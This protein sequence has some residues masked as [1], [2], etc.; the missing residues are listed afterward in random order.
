MNRALK[1][2]LIFG[3]ILGSPLPET[4]AQVPKEKTLPFTAEENADG[5]RFVWFVYGTVGYSYDYVSTKE[6]PSSPAFKL[7]ANVPQDQDIAWWPDFIGLYSAKSRSVSFRG[8]KFSIADLEKEKGPAK[9]FEY[10]ENWEK[11]F[12]EK[13]RELLNLD[14]GNGILATCSNPN[15]K[16]WFD[17][18]SEFPSKDGVR[19]IVLKRT[20]LRDSSGIDV[21]PVISI[22]LEQLPRG[23]TDLESY[24]S[25]KSNP[26]PIE[27]NKIVKSKER[28]IIHGTSNYGGN[29]HIILQSFTIQGSTGIHVV[30]D[31]FE[32][33]FPRVEEDFLFWVESSSFQKAD[34][35][36]P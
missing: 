23:I 14:L 20:S 6:F 25:L 36:Q 30:C 24:S 10:F 27:S 26:L 12:N 28:Y 4:F 15:K 2:I 22:I 21:R 16:R 1:A 9:Y 5:A 32:T 17:S 3:T 13:N 29:K 33:V 19:V 7:V 18:S 11:P 8:Q 35:H 34:H 31:S